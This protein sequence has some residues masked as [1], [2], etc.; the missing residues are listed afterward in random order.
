MTL[1]AESCDMQMI[2]ESPRLW[3][4]CQ[5]LA[6]IVRESTLLLNMN[7][8]QCVA[9]Y[10]SCYVEAKGLGIILI[11]RALKCTYSTLEPLFKARYKQ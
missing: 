10:L 5:A 3:I 6:I 2:V 4:M 9:S 11:S 1:S 7:N 8:Y